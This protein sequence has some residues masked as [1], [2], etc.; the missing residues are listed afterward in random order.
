MS[1]TIRELETEDDWNFFT[2]LDFL[3]FITTIKDVDHFSAEELRRKYKEFEESDSLNPR[4]PNHKIFILWDNNITRAGLIW[5]CNREPFW[6][7]K[8]QHIWIYNLHIIP[9][10][11]KQG[12]ARK[13]MLKA[14]KWCLEQGLDTLALHAIEDNL[15]VRKLYESLNYKLVETHNESCFYEKKL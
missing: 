8:E 6:R 10:F 12:L 14:E 3:S 15:A 2:D 11:R 7:F 4:E 9:Q 13:L 5:L 1:F